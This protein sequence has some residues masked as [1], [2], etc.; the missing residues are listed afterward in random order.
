M[1]L[2][3]VSLFD[4]TSAPPRLASKG[5]A[6]VLA[7]GITGVC[8]L[9]GCGASLSRLG[10]GSGKILAVGA[11]SQYAN[12][13]A[14]IGGSYVHVDA[15]ESN[16]NIDPHDFEASPT[17]AQEVATAR[18][19]VQ[20]GLGYD[21]YM[22]KIEAASPSSSRKV[23]DVQR[24]LHLPGSTR[25]PHLWYKPQTM[26]A[27]GRRL[28]VELSAIQPSHAAYFQANDQR[29]ERSLQ[30]WLAGLRQFR[31]A[32]PHVPVATTEPVADYMLEA[33]GVDNRT[34]F[35]LQAAI[36]NGTDP[37]P[38]SV[39][40]QRRLLSRDEVDAF[41]YNQQVT[42]PLTESFIKLAERS[43]VP[44]VGVYETMPRGYDYQSWMLAEL[45]ALQRA[46]T[47]RVSTRR[48]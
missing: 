45:E 12:V 20:N 34:P 25:N 26:P 2:D 29:F 17:I 24:L 10:I 23:I 31:G 39:T 13:I 30:P 14:Q 6:L 47:E 41:V 36:M 46:V 44:V 38:Q 5:R 48:L 27:L 16:P 9:T 37:S 11:E 1:R 40:I 7:F 4:M 8:L 19:V 3:L 43:G 42:D 33:A 18:L 22:E 15:V 28:V 21:S 32:H 35:S